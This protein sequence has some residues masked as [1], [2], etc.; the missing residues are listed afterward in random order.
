MPLESVTRA[1]SDAI[2]AAVGVQEKLYV[3]PAVGAKAVPTTVVPE[4]KS[5]RATVVPLLATAVALTVAAVP[6]VSDEPLVG[7]VSET[8]GTPAATVTLT[9]EEVMAAPLESVTRA[10]SAAAPVAVGVQLIV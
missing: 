8:V 9:V 3:E 1:V 5:T 10:V 6:S 7:A 2:P 4:R